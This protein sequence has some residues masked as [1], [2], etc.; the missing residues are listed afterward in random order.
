MR[1]QSVFSPLR[2]VSALLLLATL[3][4]VATQ[5]VRYSRLRAN[6]PQ[7]MVIAGVPVG[8]LDRQQ[9]A[10]RLLEAYSTP[11]ELLYNQAAV[12]ISPVVVDF[13]LDLEA[14]LSAAD[15]Q[16]ILPQFWQGFWDYLWGRETLPASIP[17]RSSYSEQRLRVFLKD[18]I[19][20]RYDQPPTSARP[21]PGSVEFQPGQQGMV[22]NIDESVV[23]IESALKSLTQRRVSLPLTRT[24][25]LRPAF[26]NLQVLLQQ[27]L[28]IE[29]Y[30]GI[31]GIYLLDLQT[32]QEL[33]LGYRAGEDLAVQPDIAFT[34]S[35][36]IK[37]PIM[38][39]AYRRMNM[40]EDSEA[41]KL[42]S[43]MIEKSGNEAADWLMDRVIDPNRAPL[44]VTEDMQALGMENTFLAGYFSLGSPLLARIQ[45]ASNQRA[46]VTTNPDLYNQ[47]T[48]VEMGML[49]EDIYHC[50]Q[51]GGGALIAAFPGQITQD[52]CRQMVEHLINNRLPSLLTAGVPE[53]TPIAHKHGWVSDNGIITTICDAGIIYS[54][55]GNYVFAVYLY[56]PVQLV[57]DP[58]S[59]LIARLSQAV[60][61]YYNIPQ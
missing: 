32:G 23:L 38:V 37:I 25:P 12:Q 15:Q 59:A 10:Q 17:L 46:D 57:W 24:P 7:G 56:H 42:M 27:T 11:V 16:R 60:Y 53:G 30:D 3:I 14:M 34:A 18:E 4:L 51:D 40:G 19:A 49:L 36:T 2:L 55:G 31:S 61:N 52:E 13:Q 41:D 48:P 29:N 9:A 5:L 33:H 47:T 43:D 8:G 22:L 26:Q 20:Q 1:R 6:L 50:A 39:S 44:V 58:A 28:Q 45:T 21:I 35:S 54:P